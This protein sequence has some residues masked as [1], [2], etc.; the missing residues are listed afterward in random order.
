MTLMERAKKYGLDKAY[1][2]LDKDP[3]TNIPKLMELVDKVAGDEFAG[4]RKAFR[5]AIESKNNWYQ[6]IRSLW[7]DIDDGVRRTF[8]ENFIINASI[9]GYPRQVKTAEEHGCNVPWAILMDP[10]SA[11][12]LHC[13]GCWAAEYGDKLNM[14]PETLDSAGAQKGHHQAL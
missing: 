7:T 8:F 1:D 9:I 4:Q 12:N 3:D 14:S 5:E 6:L 10:T 13:T 2:Y 11:C